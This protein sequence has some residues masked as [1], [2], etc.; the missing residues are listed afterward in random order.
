MAPFCSRRCRAGKSE[1]G[2]T[3][4]T[5]RVSCWMRSETP[6]PCSG[7]SARVRRMRSSSVPCRRS[8]GC[9]MVLSTVY[10]SCYR[11]SIGDRLGSRDVD[12]AFAP[13]GLASDAGE[14]GGCEVRDEL[15]EIAR[16]FGLAGEAA[17]GVGLAGAAAA[18]F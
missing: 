3:W 12:F 15:G 2:L 8:E 14:A 18:A 9:G 10:R 5:P 11:P 7:P 4:K 16:V 17:E 1:P 6:R 13:D